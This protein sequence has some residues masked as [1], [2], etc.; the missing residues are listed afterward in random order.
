METKISKNKA[1]LSDVII[2]AVEGGIGYWSSVSE[3][4]HGY[5]DGLDE[6]NRQPATALVHVEDE[7]GTPARDPLPLTTTTV[8]KAFRLICDKSV[9]NLSVNPEWRKR[10]VAAYWAKDSCDIDAGDADQIVQ[11]ALLGEVVYG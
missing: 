11:I 8:A 5:G 1:F 7:D 3:Y 9:D 6:D 2:T 4:R 10:M